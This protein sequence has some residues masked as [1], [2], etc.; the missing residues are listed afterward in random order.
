[1]EMYPTVFQCSGFAGQQQLSDGSFVP[2]CSTEFALV[3]ADSSSLNL[4]PD[5][6]AGLMAAILALF[7]VA[8]VVRVA[9]RAFRG[10]S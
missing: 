6:V 9:T 8:Y 3:P 7:A 5:A 1:M 2:T 10:V 4:S